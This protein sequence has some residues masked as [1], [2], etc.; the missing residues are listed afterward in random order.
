MGGHKMSI[1]DDLKY[2]AHQR[3]KLAKQKEAEKTLTEK[4]E[5]TPEYVALQAIKKEIGNTKDDASRAELQIKNNVIPEFG[6][7]DKKPCD[8]V[9]IKEFSV[10]RVLDE[11]EA[12]RWASENAP[13]V[14]TLNKSKFDRA[15]K[16]LEL[17]FIYK[18]TEYRAQIASDLS[19][20]EEEENAEE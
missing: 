18:D 8:G 5:A 9:Q 16:G 15:V 3:K 1:K 13:G 11:K 20:Y 6:L 14:I 2:L 19:M 10:I 12:K 17:D 4:L 7:D